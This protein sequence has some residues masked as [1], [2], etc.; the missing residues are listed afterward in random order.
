VNNAQWGD[1]IAMGLFLAMSS[2]VD[3]LAA[4]VRSGCVTPC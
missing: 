3:A 4:A 2:V 1:E